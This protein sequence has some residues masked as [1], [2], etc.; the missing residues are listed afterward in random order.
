[1]VTPQ[2]PTRMFNGLDDDIYSEYAHE[3]N[4]KMRVPKRIKATGEIL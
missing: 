1:M 3:I 4:D 2:S